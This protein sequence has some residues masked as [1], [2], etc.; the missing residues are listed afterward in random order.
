MNGKTIKI[1]I[2][3]VEGVNKSAELMLYAILA[4]IEKHYPNAEVYLPISQFPK[5][6]DYIRTSLTLKPN[7]NRIVR[8]M[9]KYHITGVL[10]RLGLRSRYLYNLF[11]IKGVK[12]YIDASG[13]YFSDQMIPSE[14]VARDLHILLEGY[15]KQGTKIIFLPQAFG[16]F[17][18][19]ASRIATSA[20]LKYS[21]LLFVRDRISKNY[22]SKLNFE[23]TKIKEAPDFT[24][25]IAGKVSSE[26]DY[27]RGRVCIIPNSQIIRKGTMTKESYIDMIIDI[28]KTIYDRGREVFLLNHVDEQDLIK[29]IID[30]VAYSIPMIS[31]LDAITIKGIIGL[32]YLCISSR[33]HG[34]ASAFSSNVP[35]LTTSWNHKYQELLELY[36]MTDSLLTDV[37]DESLNK[38]KL[39]L[40]EDVN[41]KVRCLLISKNKIVKQS[42]EDMW[43]LIWTLE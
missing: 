3:G 8:F 21:D 41:D 25:L 35:C 14:R 19:K 6:F 18:R 2:S 39:Y 40:D 34:V 32:S 30:R 20:A 1:V 13:L 17:E 12:Y 15:H 5:G 4:Q 42:V 33:F 9:G 37:K 26:Y 16:P 11:P 31:D 29:E 23:S 7:P 28:I 10:S 24:S 36:G 22:L 27:L 43:N 38:V